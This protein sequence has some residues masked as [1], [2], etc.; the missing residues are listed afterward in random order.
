MD[1]DEYM[2][3]IVL[4]WHNRDIT[5]LFHISEQREKSR[6]G[7]HSDFISKLPDY[8]LDF[9]SK[10]GNLDIEIEAKL[11]EQAILKLY[12]KYPFLIYEKYENPALP[13]VAAITDRSEIKEAEEYI[14]NSKIERKSLEKIGTAIANL[15]K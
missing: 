6:I 9:P 12:K 2:D 13:A 11:K 5:P 15:F 3:R 10:Y 4:T 14:Q 7:T 1:I 8:Y